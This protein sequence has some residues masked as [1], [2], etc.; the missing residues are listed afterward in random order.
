MMENPDESLMD[1][2][3]GSFFAGEKIIKYRDNMVIENVFGEGVN[4]WDKV[5]QICQEAIVNELKLS[6]REHPF[7][8]SEP[9]IH[10]RESRVTLTELMF[11]KF[12]IPAFYIVK[13]AVLSSFASG[14]S[15][16]LVLDSGAYTTSAVP[17]H[18]GYVLQKS[19]VK[20]NVGG[21]MITDSLVQ[22]LSGVDIKP[23]FMFSKNVKCFVEAGEIQG[24]PEFS[25]EEIPRP[26][27]HQSYIDFS[28]REIV[29][30]IKET[31]F[32]VSD[33][34]FSDSA[35][36]NVPPVNYEL[37]DGSNV[38]LGNERFRIPELLFSGGVEGAIGFSGVHQMVYDSITRCDMDIRR[39]LYGNIVVTG[40]NSL[41]G[42]FTDRLH[43][44]LTELTT[45][46]MKVKL[47]APQS[48]IERRFSSWIGGSILASLGSF[49]Q[50]W[51][52]KQ[53]YDEHGAILVERK[54]P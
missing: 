40:G 14:R 18:D 47:I 41:F 46:N 30:D 42:G 45:Q 3:G 19:I 25:I 26:Y 27:A 17:V 48:T 20:F 32:K 7:L 29:R 24:P 2:D 31:T 52:S 4:K 35:F 39:E 9:S 1:V 15:T 54:C 8:L 23:H 21:E 28:V 44:K 50:M 33:N 34:T 53:E 6:P 43:K 5:E 10:D 37:P 12:Q 51:M 16:S 13:N 36:T 38:Q 49:Q 11:E 22:Q